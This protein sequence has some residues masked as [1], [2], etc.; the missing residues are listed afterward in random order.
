M[1]L[2]FFSD[3]EAASLIQLNTAKFNNASGDPTYDSAYSA[4]ADGSGNIYVLGV[5]TREDY[6]RDY[7]IIKY[8]SDLKTVLAK[9]YVGSAGDD[10]SINYYK[11]GIA[12]DSFGKVFMCG[13]LSGSGYDFFTAK[14]DSDLQI[15]SSAAY[16]SGGNDYAF[17]L[18]LDES[19][20]LYVC[21]AVSNA[22]FDFFTV[23]YNSGLQVLSSAAYDSGGNDYAFGI[24]VDKSGNIIVAGTAS[25]NFFTVKYDSDL[26]VISSVPFNTAS[27]SE[28]RDIAADSSGNYIVTGSVSNGADN[29]FFAVKYDSDLQAVSSFTLNGGY[30]DYFVDAVIDSK[31]N[32]FAAGIS[33]K[34]SGEPYFKVFKFDSGLNWVSTAAYV[35][36]SAGF[37]ITVDSRDNIIACGAEVKDIDTDSFDYLTVKYNG[38]PVIT[39][40]N[41]TFIEAGNTEEITVSGYNFFYNLSADF[42]GSGITINSTDYNS[43]TRITLDVTASGAASGK[44]DLTVTNIDGVSGTK[45]NA[46]EAGETIMKAVVRET[47]GYKGTVNPDKGGKVSIYFKGKEK[48][49][50]TLR[51]FTLAGEEIHKEQKSDDSQGCFEWAPENIASGVYVAHIKG[52]GIDEY[53]KIA[54]LR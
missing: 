49:T 7:C 6:G 26:T 52:P 48:G 30:E 40:V 42:S 47:G 3:A 20:N 27:G 2:L 25:G 39:S 53:K 22:D 17:D 38:P 9:G 29:D 14:L 44:Y 16:D 32:I 50:F 13:G 12:V 5:S 37:G 41:P 36:S 1:F 43:S 11:A 46:L 34:T 21:G 45:N 24:D 23:K 4:A 51:I 54:V 8:D 15:I 19:G 28:A 33:E 35:N 10:H 18:A 31:G